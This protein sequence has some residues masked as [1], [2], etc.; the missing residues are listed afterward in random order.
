[1]P[2][3]PGKKPVRPA[4]KVQQKAQGDLRLQQA[5]E[6]K[7]T[8]ISAYIAELNATKQAAGTPAQKSGFGQ[9]L[10]NIFRWR[11]KPA[12]AKKKTES[13]GKNAGKIEKTV[14]EAKKAAEKAAAANAR[15]AEAARKLR[16]RAKVAAS[17]KPFADAC[18]A[19]NLEPLEAFEHYYKVLQEDPHY[20]KAEFEN[21]MRAK[22]NDRRF[23][24]TAF[25]VKYIMT[26]VLPKL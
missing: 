16:G 7:G 12:Q 24:S 4:N 26:F 18:R 21:M 8:K 5:V 10:K 11:K 9:R 6:E 15:E 17:Y 25:C 3:P 2:K 20:V 14:E 13:K 22:D 1:M 19:K 23:S